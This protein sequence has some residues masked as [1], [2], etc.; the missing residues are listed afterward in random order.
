MSPEGV[1]SDDSRNFSVLRWHIC[2]FGFHHQTKTG[3]SLRMIGDKIEEVPLP[4]QDE[5][6]ALGWEM[7]E[8]SDGER[9][10]ADLTADLPD[11]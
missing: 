10:V 1:L 2:D 9:L 4:H 5:K 11:S 7:G 8:V 6:L 3:I